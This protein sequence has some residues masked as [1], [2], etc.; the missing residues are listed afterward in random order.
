MF[1][2]VVVSALLCQYMI[3]ASNSLM[4][5]SRVMPFGYISVIVSFVA[6]I[7]IFKAEFNFLAVLGILLTSLGLIGKYLLEKQQILPPQIVD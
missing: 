4:K 5:P 1:A 7:Y 2:G 6:D 3:F